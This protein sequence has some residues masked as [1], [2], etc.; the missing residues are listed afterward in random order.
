MA[1][2]VV[3]IS[4]VTAAGGEAVGRMVAESLGFRYVDEEV[5]STAAARAGIDPDALL[6]IEHHKGFLTRLLEAIAAPPA[7]AESYFRPASRR[8]YYP[9]GATPPALSFEEGRRLIQDAIVELARQ[10]RVVIVAHAASFALASE[11]G[12]LRVHVTASAK[13][14]VERLW[15]PNKLVSEDDHAKT[16]AESDRRRAKYLAMFYEIER[17]LPTHYD[18]VVNTDALAVERAVAAVVAVAQS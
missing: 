4:Q 16:I 11:R 18:L 14:R 7:E 12:V 8:E 3:C 1:Y 9:A 13:T 5:V 2:D 15:I 6:S 17:E 10:G